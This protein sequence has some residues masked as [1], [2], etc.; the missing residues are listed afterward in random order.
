MQAFHSEY[1]SEEILIRSIIALTAQHNPEAAKQMEDFWY[2]EEESLV[3][4]FIND[5]PGRNVTCGHIGFEI[6]KEDL[7]NNPPWD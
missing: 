7:E 4:D 5:P 1:D 2:F 3:S 6:S